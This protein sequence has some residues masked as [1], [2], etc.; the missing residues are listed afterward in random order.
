VQISSGL[1]TRKTL[2]LKLPQIKITANEAE[3][4]QE[5]TSWKHKK[6]W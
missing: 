5:R 4:A 3:R 2:D 1:E 6:Y